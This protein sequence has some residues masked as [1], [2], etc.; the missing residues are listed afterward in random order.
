MVTSP[1]DPPS[2]PPCKPTA[3]DR[4]HYLDVVVALG[5]GNRVTADTRKKHPAD[6]ALWKSAKPGE[7][8]W[9]SPWGEGRPGWHIE[10]SAMIHSLMGRVIDIHGGGQ[11]LVR[12][13]G[14]CTKHCP[15]MH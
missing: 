5:G 13:F 15:G 1:P 7:P 12:E 11:D 9:P 10:C 4:C 14:R 8:S 2:R 3:A 6:F